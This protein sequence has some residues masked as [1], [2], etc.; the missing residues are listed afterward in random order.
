MAKPQVVSPLLQIFRFVSGVSAEELEDPEKAVHMLQRTVRMIT[1]YTIVAALAVFFLSIPSFIRPDGELHVE[2][3]LAFVEL[4]GPLV[5]C[6]ALG[7]CGW[8]LSQ[9]KSLLVALGLAGLA[10]FDVSVYAQQTTLRDFAMLLM[11]L[12]VLIHTL[13][14]VGLLTLGRNG[15]ATE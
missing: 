1:A 9:T 7:L 8:Y 12:M 15:T 4:G 6:L 13:Q 10:G 11:S 2:N 5:D 3:F 14:I